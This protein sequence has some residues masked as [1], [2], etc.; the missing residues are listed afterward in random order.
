MTIL[1]AG[2]QRLRDLLL[3]SLAQKGYTLVF[4]QSGEEFATLVR[5]LPIDLV[6]MD[7]DTVARSSFSTLAELKRVLESLSVPVVVAA[8]SAGVTPD[9]EELRRLL[10]QNS[11]AVLN[12]PLDLK[13]LEQEVARILGDEFPRTDCLTEQTLSRLTD[14]ELSE[15]EAD[16]AQDHLSE[17]DTCE[18]RFEEWKRTDSLFRDSFETVMMT[19]MHSSTDCISP[20]R[21]TAYFR[22]GLPAA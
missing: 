1:V 17:C 4:V 16:R 3:H 19:R 11:A 5:T 6:I 2:D 7:M 15:K 20:K 10:R 18:R 12:R 8:E 13:Q 22:D 21:L 14:G 9:L